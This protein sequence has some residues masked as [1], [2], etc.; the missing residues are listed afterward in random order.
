MT[1]QIFVF[2]YNHCIYESAMAVMSCHRTKVGAYK[3]MNTYLNDRFNEERENQIR[4]GK[5]DRLDDLFS[6]ERWQV[7]PMQVI[8]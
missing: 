6:D 3:S 7:K 8:D 4:Y 5:N 1:Q 2:M